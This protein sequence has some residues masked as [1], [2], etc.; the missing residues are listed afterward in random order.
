VGERKRL[1]TAAAAVGLSY[2]AVQVPTTAALDRRAGAAISRPLGRRADAAI[3]AG[4]DL[5]SVFAIAGISTALAA[6]G[7]RRAALDVAAAGAIGW[8]VAQ[9]MKPLTNRPRPYQADGTV[10]LVSEPAGASWPSGHVAVAGAMAAATAP[11]MSS[12]GRLGA[13]GLAAFVGLSRIYVGVHYLTDVVAGLGVGVASA[14]LWRALRQR[15][16]RG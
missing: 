8:T 6:T 16:T 12:R 10:R 14:S 15:F 3:S 4:T 2:A 11:G 5:G 7:R 13:A 1:L 9:A